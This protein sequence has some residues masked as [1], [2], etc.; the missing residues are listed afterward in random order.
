MKPTGRLDDSTQL[1]ALL[2]V[3]P[4]LVVAVDRDLALIFMN[5]A[6]GGFSPEQ[7]L[8]KSILEFMDPAFR[9]KVRELIRG[10]FATG[11]ATQYEIPA[12]DA[13]GKRQWHQGTICPVTSDGVPTVA[14]IST[15]NVTARKLAEEEASKL[16]RLVPVCSWCRKVRNDEG[17]WASLEV[18]IEE[19]KD[20][21]V[22][23]GMCPGCAGKMLDQVG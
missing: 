20:A 16:R 23:H 3:L 19:Q 15:T 12:L 7:V 14:V 5:R 13:Q 22:T 6:Q 11:K 8:G 1:L 9:D 18:Y 10:V 4:E 17:F 2:S 21:R